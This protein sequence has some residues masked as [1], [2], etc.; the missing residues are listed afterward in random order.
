MEHTIKFYP[1]E[2]ADCTLIKLGNGMTVIVDCQLFNNL[3]NEDGNQVRYDV[4]KD[5]LK[6]LAKDSNG[7]PYVDLFVSTHPHDDHCKGFDGNFY[8]GN[9]D[10]YDLKKNENE[11]IIGELWV[12]PRGIGNELAD[13]AETIRQEA[14]RRRKLYDED[15]TFTGNYG[16]FLR[17]IGYNKQANFDTRYGFVPGTLVTSVNGRDFVWLEM[18]I[19]APFKEDVDKSKEEDDKNATS[20]VV[21]YS[22]KAQ[23]KDNS[24]AIVC[25]LLM[26]G[27]AEHEI[28]QHIIDNNVDDSRLEWNLF[29]TPHHCSWTFFNDS[30]NK[31]EVMPSA[32]II[33]SKQL[34]NNSYIIASSVKILDDD[35]NPPCY[36]AKTEYKNRLKNKDNFLN[37]AVDN[38]EGAIPQPIVFKI[39]NH[40]K[41]KVQSISSSGSSVIS[42]PAPRAGSN[43]YAEKL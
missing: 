25:K 29:M 19:H 41:R 9:P 36:Q 28:W 42:R 12:T 11:I 43:N 13:S 22:F 3:N 16:N 8:H 23:M 32:E 30:N 33:L 38:T 27:D 24:T 37:T 26:G 18:F 2:N 4:K 17:I 35:N 1:V 20:I 34:N 7:Y 10:D 39:D 15:A 40:G 21:Q 14:K 31:G 5:L 6:E